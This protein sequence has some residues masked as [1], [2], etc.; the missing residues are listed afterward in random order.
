M[1]Y[2]NFSLFQEKQIHSFVSFFCNVSVKG[3]SNNETTLFFHFVCLFLLIRNFYPSKHHHATRS[4]FRNW[5]KL[6]KTTN[7]MAWRRPSNTKK[8]QTNKQY[9]HK[10]NSITESLRALLHLK[11]L[12]H[13]LCVLAS[14]SFSLCIRVINTQYKR[15]DTPH[16]TTAIHHHYHPNKT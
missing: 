13:T 6:D 2:S 7:G 8:K 4:L 16:A 11:H 3:K 12:T 15:I 14:R 10:L 1:L 9:T 5:T